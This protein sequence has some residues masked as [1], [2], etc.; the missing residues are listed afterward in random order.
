MS[1]KPIIALTMGDP[2]GVGP[3]V[4]IKA[5]ENPRVREGCRSV[6][7][8]NHQVMEKVAAGKSGA[9]LPLNPFK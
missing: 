5:I 4:V 6:I 7:I 1:F 9:E 8:G 3:E 2:A